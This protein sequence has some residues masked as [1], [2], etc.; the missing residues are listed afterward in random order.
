MVHRSPFLTQSVAVIRSLRSLARVMIR[1]PTLAWLPSA[2]STCRLRSRTSEAVIAGALVEPADQLPGRR[3]HDGVQT[4]GAVGPPAVE[5]GVEGGG[6]VADV[7]ASPVQVEAERFGSAVAEGEGGGGFGR[8]GK[9]VQFSQ[10]DRAMAG[11][12]VT[13]DAAGADRG[14]LLIIA[15]QPDTAAPPH[16]ELDGGVQGEGVGHPGFVDDHQGG[17]VDAFGPVGQLIVVDGP[18]EFRQRFGWRTGGV[19]EL[20]SCGG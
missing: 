7:D 3:Q 8:V 14:E 4:S 1:S 15:D 16:N 20:H 6:G 10:P 19:A 13:E 9:A 2:N 12:D 5:D 17:S 11:L 18:G